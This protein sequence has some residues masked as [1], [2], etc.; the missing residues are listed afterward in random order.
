MCL[1]AYSPTG[2]E[3]PR[4]AWKTAQSINSDGIGVMSEIGVRKFTGKRMCKRAYHYVRDFVMP[5]GVPYAVHWRYATHGLTDESNVHPHT[6]PDGVTQLM[7]NGVIGWCGYDRI[8]SDTAVFAELLDDAPETAS[9]EY[10]AE[11]ARAVGYSN[12]LCLMHADYT[13]SLANEDMGTWINGIWYSNEYSLPHSMQTREYRTS[14]YAYSP[15]R[16]VAA[17]SWPTFDRNYNRTNGNVLVNDDAHADDFDSA[18]DYAETV[19]DLRNLKRGSGRGNYM[20]TLPDGYR[21]G[22]SC[23][24]DDDSLMDRCYASPMDAYYAELEAAE[25]PGLFDDGADI[26]EMAALRRAG[27]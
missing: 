11:L 7:H 24:C 6:L 20:L 23:D 1:I 2:A 21:H 22:P 10:A 14:L 27:V 5:A 18:D 9:P 16:I 3:I 25:S 8:K 17:D 13:F 26:G 12:L 19:V 15:S 4:D